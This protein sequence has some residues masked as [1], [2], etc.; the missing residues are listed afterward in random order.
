MPDLNKLNEL[1]VSVRSK[2]L[3]Q[4]QKSLENPAELVAS[5]QYTKS[6]GTN[7]GMYQKSDPNL[8]DLWDTVINQRSTLGNVARVQRVQ[9][10]E[11]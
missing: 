1:H 9:G 10:P 8:T 5:T 11:G 3:E 4:I 6:D 7:Y 2:I